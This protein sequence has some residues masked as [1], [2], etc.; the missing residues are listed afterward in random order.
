MTDVERDE[1]GKFPAY[2]WPGGYPIFYVTADSAALCP[3]CVNDPDNPAHTGAE[4][5]TK[6]IDDPQWRIVASDVNWEDT[7]LYCDHCNKQIP[8]AYG[9]DGDEEELTEES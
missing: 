5:R 1:N 9:D 6:G 2:A 8:S 3:D 4:A 7:S